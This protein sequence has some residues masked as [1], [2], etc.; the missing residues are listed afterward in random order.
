MG[1]SYLG[2]AGGG[3]SPG[4]TDHAAL[5]NLT[6]AASGHTGFAP[7]VSPTFTGQVTIN[8]GTITA[9]AP[10][11]YNVTWNNAAVKFTG[12][13][14]DVTET[15]YD[16]QSILMAVLIH[17][18]D[19]CFAVLADGA[20]GIGSTANFSSTHAFFHAAMGATLDLTSSDNTRMT[21]RSYY[22]S[23]EAL[24]RFMRGVDTTYGWSVGLLGNSTDLS[25]Y[26]HTSG[27]L[28]SPLTL[29]A[30]DSTVKF[31]I[32][33]IADAGS[34]AHVVIGYETEEGPQSAAQSG[35]LPITL[36]DDGRAWIPVWN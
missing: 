21:I 12:F 33:V 4:V 11:S 19:P 7:S 32:P 6:F 9:N 26:N 28:G 5:T 24:I 27:Q 31:G 1:V 2:M 34:G 29:I 17:G 13:Q 14:I 16:S 23:F 3:G 8:H 18:Q 30:A 10:F 25:F 15:A 35:W 20:M 22:V 36:S